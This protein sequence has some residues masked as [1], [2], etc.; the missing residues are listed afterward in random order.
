[1]PAQSIFD[2]DT[3]ALLIDEA[4]MEDNIRRVQQHADSVGLALRPHTKTHRSP[5]IARR[6]VA[7][8]ACGVTVAKLDEA[9]LMIDAGI[10]DLFLANEIVGRRKIERLVELRRRA[11][12][13]VCVDSMAMAEPLSVA[14]EG[15][16]RPLDVMLELDTGIGRCGVLPEA[17][18]EL[19]ARLAELNG[20]KLIGVMAYA[21]ASYAQPSPEKI[22]EAADDEERTLRQI[23]DGLEADG[24][25][26]KVVSGGCT[27]SALRYRGIGLDEIR[28]GTYIYND[29]NQL[30]LW[31]CDESQI[32]LTVLATVISRPAPDRAITDAGSKAFA[33]EFSKRLNRLG[34]ARDWPGA[35]VV[36][37]NEEHGYIDLSEAERK[38]NVGEKLRLLPSR[39]GTAVNLHH[40]MVLHRGEEVVGVIPIAARGRSR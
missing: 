11:S 4:V 33:A 14:F 22:Q 29:L 38:P 12:I 6:Q 31:A 8:G 40:E 20:L 18:S 13:R 21:G 36:K 2:L 24:H 32:A 17:A 34:I 9:E 10:D 30:E 7:A 1:M 5:D 23:A 3:P 27:P 16:D 39:C 25:E 15:E 35:T 28:P 19:A 26:M 37:T